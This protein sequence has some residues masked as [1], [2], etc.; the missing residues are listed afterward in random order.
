LGGRRGDTFGIGWFLVGASD[1][2]G[3]VPSA[4]FGPRD[5]QG[6]EWFYNIQATPWLNVTPDVQWI[7]PGLGAISTDNAF[8]YGLRVNATF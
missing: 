3:P 5:G 4:L 6:V 7:R 2:F 8:V 1:Q